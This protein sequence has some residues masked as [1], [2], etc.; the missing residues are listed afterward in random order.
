MRIG[1]PTLAFASLLLCGSSGV[2]MSWAQGAGPLNTPVGGFTDGKAAKIVWIVPG[3]IKKDNISTDFMCT[4]LEASGVKVDI[5]VELFDVDGTQL[6][7]I[8]GT[9][10]IAGSTCPTGAVLNVESGSTKTIGIEGTVQLHEDCKIGLGPA[11]AQGSARIVSTSS[12]IVCD[13]IAL[14]DKHVV[15]APNVCSTCPPPPMTSLK[16]MRPKKQIGD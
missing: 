13:A 5:G 11:L 4:S 10:P 6:N 3:V 9:I 15:T 7:K 8:D 14:D 2:T 12:R 16:V 1:K